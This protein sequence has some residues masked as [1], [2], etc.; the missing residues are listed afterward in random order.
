ML[1]FMGVLKPVER[2]P[3]DG[4]QKPFFG[5]DWRL[6]RTEKDAQ[7]LDGKWPAESRERED[8]GLRFVNL[9]SPPYL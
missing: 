8:E 9:L 1:H 2:A 5:P 3:V 7:Y 4:E 6:S